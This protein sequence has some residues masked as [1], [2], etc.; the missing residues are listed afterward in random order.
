MESCGE[1]QKMLKRPVNLPRAYEQSHADR[2]GAQRLVHERATSD[3]ISHGKAGYLLY[4]EAFA[5]H[6]P[7]IISR[8]IV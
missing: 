8:Q 4:C 5:S 3:G 6:E 1:C 7:N 2:V